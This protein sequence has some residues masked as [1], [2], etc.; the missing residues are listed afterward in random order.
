MFSPI[1]ADVSN[2]TQGGRLW[3]C[4]HILISVALLGEF[5][6]TFDDLRAERAKTEARIRVLTTRVNSQMLDN[7]L[8]HAKALRPAIERDGKGLTEM[9]YILAMMLEL[10][11]V[12]LDIV[13]PFVQQ[14]RILDV[15]GNARLARDDLEESCDKTFG[16]LAR[17]ASKRHTISME[18]GTIHRSVT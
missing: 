6:S 8:E 15:D 4:F 7:L 17:A 16:E 9:E 2:S 13:K 1:L 10:G 18:A 3:S 14:F 5:I 11:V 12:E